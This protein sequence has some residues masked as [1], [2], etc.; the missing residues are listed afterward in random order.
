MED[1]RE[2]AI[3]GFDQRLGKLSHNIKKLEKE[4]ATTEDEKKGELEDYS[5]RLDDIRRQIEDGINR[6]RI[7]RGEFIYQVDL[8]L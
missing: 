7:A 1:D 2:N 4:S 6:I 5:R 8:A 3:D